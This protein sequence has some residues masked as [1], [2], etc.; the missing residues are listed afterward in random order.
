MLFSKLLTN[1]LLPHEA[2]TMLT[3]CPINVLEVYFQR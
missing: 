3:V 2:Q 1:V